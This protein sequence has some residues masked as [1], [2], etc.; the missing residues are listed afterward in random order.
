VNPGTAD[1]VYVSYTADPWLYPPTLSNPWEP[2]KSKRPLPRYIII[3]SNKAAAASRHMQ[4]RSIFCNK[5]PVRPGE[6]FQTTWDLSDFDMS[7]TGFYK[8]KIKRYFIADKDNILTPFK[9]NVES[10]TLILHGKKNKFEEAHVTT[11]P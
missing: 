3:S 6:Q 7:R 2:L 5:D 11:N 1:V 8:V 4:I 9:Y 10:N